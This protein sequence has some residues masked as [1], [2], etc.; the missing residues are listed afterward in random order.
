[1]TPISG[2]S[3]EIPREPK[4]Y[5]VSFTVVAVALALFSSDTQHNKSDQADIEAQ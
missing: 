1:M 2:F 4:F 5:W 3:T